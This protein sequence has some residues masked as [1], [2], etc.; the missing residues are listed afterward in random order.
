MRNYH[1]RTQSTGSTQRPLVLINTTPSPESWMN[2]PACLRPRGTASRMRSP[3]FTAGG[4][5]AMSMQFGPDDGVFE[6]EDDYEGWI[7]ST[8]FARSSKSSR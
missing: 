2:S 1:D 3:D 8:L 7:A 4:F 5:T 6:T